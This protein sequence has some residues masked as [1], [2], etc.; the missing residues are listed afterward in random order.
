MHTDIFY[1]SGTGNSLWV[2]KTLSSCLSANLVSISSTIHETVVH[3]G[4]NTLCLVFPAYLAQRYGLPGIV[5][6]FVQK[7]SDL[8][9]K[10]VFAVCTCGGW[11]LVN[12]L[13]TLKRLNRVLKNHGAKNL[14]GAFSIK[15]PMNNLDYPSPLINQNQEIMFQ[16][17]EEKTK[18]ICNRILAVKPEPY[19]WLKSMFNL[20]M[21]PLYASIQT[22]YVRHLR[23]MAHLTKDTPVG[24][25]NLI[26][27][28]DRSIRFLEDRCIGCS[29]CAQVCPAKNIQMA[30]GKPTWTHRCEMC[31][32][33]DE[34]C[35]QK[36]IHH[37][38]KTPGKDYHHPQI[39]RTDMINQT[40]PRK[41][42]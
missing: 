22:L 34:W 25:F 4:A 1:F 14:R 28:S 21:K 38:C 30:D 20:M 36:A 31:L 40:K 3:T 32:A 24:Y 27:H 12:A 29:I 6:D 41:E 18:A 37:W 11:E 13:P 19:K 39:D 17:A 15:L 7:I 16:R 8:N 2:A 23:K 10:E 42:R 9:E 33:C 35:P 26:G 5:E